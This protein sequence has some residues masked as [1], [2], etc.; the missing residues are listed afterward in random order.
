MLVWLSGAL[1]FFVVFVNVAMIYLLREIAEKESIQELKSGLIAYQRFSEQ[2]KALILA[3]ANSIAQIPYLKA[4]LTIPNVDRETL[5]VTA[6]GIANLADVELFI[7]GDAEGSPLLV[8]GPDGSQPTQDAISHLKMTSTP[9]DPYFDY[10]SHGDRIFQRMTV[11]VIS[12]DYIVGY[13]SIGQSIDSQSA[14]A[15]IEDV[16][17]TGVAV[18]SDKDVR[19]RE[20]NVDTA[21]L[22]SFLAANA[23]ISPVDTPADTVNVARLDSESRYTLASIGLAGSGTHLVFYKIVDLVGSSAYFAWSLLIIGSVLAVALGIWMSQMIAVR[24]SRPIM[25]LAAAARRYG[26]GDLD[27]RI[28]SDKKDEIGRLSS[29]FDQMAAD[30]DNS[31]QDLVESRDA[32]QAASRAKSEFLARMSHEIR[33]P[34]NGISGMSEMLAQSNLDDAQDRCIHI[35]QRSSETLLSIVNDMLDFSKVDSGKIEL[36]VTDFDISRI[37]EDSIDMLAAQAEAK[38]LI[39][40]L[41]FDGVAKELVSGDAERIQQIVINLLMNAI[42]FTASGEIGVVVREFHREARHTEFRI[43]VTDTGIGIDAD[44]LNRVFDLFF[45]VDGSSTREY[46]GTGLGL[47][48]CKQLVE[49]IDGQI[50]VSSELGKGS[51]F[52]FTVRL[53]R[54]GRSAEARENSPSVSAIGVVEK[55]D[56]HVLLVEDNPVNRDVAVHMLKTLGCKTKIAEDGVEA[57]ECFSSENWDIVFMD[58]QMPRMDGFLATTKIRELEKASGRRPTPIVALTANAMQGDAEDCLA[59]GMNDYISKP[60]T[61]GQIRD[62]IIRNTTSGPANHYAPGR[63]KS[64]SDDGELATLCMGPIDELREFQSLGEADIVMEVVMTFIDSAQITLDEIEL[65]ASCKDIQALGVAA[66]KLKGASAAVGG[67]KLSHLC[68]VVEEAS[69]SG[70][71]IDWL[72][73]SA[74]IKQEF[75]KLVDALRRVKGATG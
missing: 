14:L 50:G 66:H 48:I 25:R 62:T 46:G 24:I 36:R 54:T 74:E 22:R 44:K 38:G 42:K 17:G 12:G 30:I 68:A 27:I 47:A 4:T 43:S 33:T 60:Y 2:S 8:L 61:F 9:G 19:V 31:R 34:M 28:N 57:L 72:Q 55:L 7:L 41:E 10:L 39:I 20:Q 75:A 53:A 29:A 1:I 56:L 69:R 73:S 59:A 26:Q 18:M 6:S 40:G 21:P 15:V 35:I 65:A 51:E 64:G 71:A 70:T 63:T 3:K 23:K 37:V 52:W 58:C 45:Q 16:S 32:A 49:L 13:V 11:A 5:L 67:Q